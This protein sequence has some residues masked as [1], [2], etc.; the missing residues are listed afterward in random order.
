M[1]KLNISKQFNKLHTLHSVAPSYREVTITTDPPEG[2]FPIGST[3]TFQCNINPPPP[4]GP[5]YSWTDSISSTYL[6]SNQPNYTIMVSSHHPSI[7]NYY[8]TVHN[9]NSVLGV[10]SITINVKSELVYQHD[11][12][13]Y[14]G[15]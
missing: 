3:V 15:H 6:S 2:P 9:G 8:C 12:L 11:R 5:S 13:A 7:G 14:T 1:Y 4:E 10:G